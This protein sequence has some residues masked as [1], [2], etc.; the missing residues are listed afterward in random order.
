MKKLLI[1]LSIAAALASSNVL[2]QTEPAGGASAGGLTVGGVTITVPGA[3]V[4]VTAIGVAASVNSG[5]TAPSREVVI[6]P[7]QPPVEPPVETCNGDDSLVDGVCI[8]STVTTTVTGTGTGTNTMT[9][10]ITV[11][12]TNTYAPS[13]SS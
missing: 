8:N 3:I 6:P 2:A 13:V 10:T 1:G 5:G 11:P 12:V 7:V 4:A 9:S